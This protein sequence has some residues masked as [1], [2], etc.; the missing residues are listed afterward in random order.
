MM[1]GFDLES[2]L[3]CEGIIGDGCGGGRIFFVEDQKLQVYDPFTKESRVLLGDLKNVI[4]I[5]K[6]GCIITIEE[7]RKNT[8]FD[9]S[10]LKS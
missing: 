4:R 8:E 7:E 9:L 1:D 2:A 6:S 10:T 5:S 3:V